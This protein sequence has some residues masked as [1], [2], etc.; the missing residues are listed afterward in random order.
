MAGKDFDELAGRIDGL[1]WAVAYLTAHLETTGLLD[2][3]GYCQTLRAK[4]ESRSDLLPLA[5]Q[6]LA[7][8][9]TELDRARQVRQSRAG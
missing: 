1:A 6:V 4:A 9:A 8:L 5:R 7:G 3:P 2:G